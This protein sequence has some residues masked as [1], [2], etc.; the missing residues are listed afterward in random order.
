[1]G[2]GVGA[3]I[4]ESVVGGFG[5]AGGVVGPGGLDGVGFAAGGV[6]I[7]SINGSTPPFTAARQ[8]QGGKADDSINDGTPPFM[9][10]GLDDDIEA[11]KRELLDRENAS[12]YGVVVPFMTA[13]RK[14]FVFKSL[15]VSVRLSFYLSL[16]YTNRHILSTL[17]LRNPSP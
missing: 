12:I 3:W 8:N 6:R 13:N 5:D 10:P 1:M 7:T 16:Q 4:G 17:L 9:G 15:H 14:R 11:V 2:A